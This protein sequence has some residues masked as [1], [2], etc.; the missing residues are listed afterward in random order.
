MLDIC[1]TNCKL[2]IGTEEVCLGIED[3]KIVSIKKLPT[4]ASS[5]IDVNSKLVLP[6]LIDAHVHFRDPGLTKKED[7]FSGSAAAAAGGFTTVIDMPNTIPPTNTTQALKEKMRIAREKSLVDFGLHV[8]VADLAS[9]K[10]LTEYKPASFKIFMDLVDCDFLIEA[11]CKINEVRDN[12]LNGVPSH[13]LISLHA[14]D[15][16]VV[17]QCTNKMKK[18]GSDP[19]LYSQARPPQAEIEAIQKAILLSKKFNQKIHFCHVSTPK[20]Q[21]IINQAKNDGLNV[22]SEITPHHLFLNSSYLRKYGNLAKTNPPLRDEKNRLTVDN[23]SQIDIVGTD[24]APHTLEEKNK[25]VWNAPPGIPGLETAL[26]LLL[27]QLNQGKIIVGDIKRLLC[28][29]PAKIFNIPNKGFI[30]KGMDADLVVIDLKKSYVIDP[31]NFQ[32]KA[33]YSPFEGFHVQGVPVMTLVR[34]Q[35]VMEKGHILK[36]QGKFIYS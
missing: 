23:L 16:D 27:T 34:G 7:F 17:K 22:T 3:G 21:K 15:P 20:S 10:E 1:I 19:E 6:G 30:R 29:N 9:I 12:L 36:N 8:G 2:D 32:S 14:E 13:P 18:E 26:P 31:A 35:K 28:E 5:T 4:D 11:F 25:D 33:K 24:H